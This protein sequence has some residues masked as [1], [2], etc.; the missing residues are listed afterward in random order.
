MATG[1]GGANQGGLPG[2]VQIQEET[3]RRATD[4]RDGNIV[5]VSSLDE[6]K[7]AVAAGKW[8]RGPWAG[9]SHL[10]VLLPRNSHSMF[11]VPWLP[12]VL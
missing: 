7:A 11:V 1:G 12:I 10:G 2:R 8:A 3:L 9:A 4:F 6:L 5:D